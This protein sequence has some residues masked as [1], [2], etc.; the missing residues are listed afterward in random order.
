MNRPAYIDLDD[1]E[2]EAF[3]SER[4]NFSPD[5][6]A[7]F[8]ELLSVWEPRID[9]DRFLKRVR[10]TGGP[11]QVAS[12]MNKLWQA[13]VGLLRTQMVEGE[14]RRVALL[15][16][17]ENSFDFY[18]EAIQEIYVEL[19]ESIGN[20]LPFRSRLEERDLSIPDSLVQVLDNDALVRL[21][22]ETEKDDRSI[23]ALLSLNNYQVI[24]PSTHIRAFTNITMLKIRYFMGNTS[25]LESIARYQDTSLM[26]VKQ[27]LGDKEPQFWL[28]L[29][30]TVVDK[31]KELQAS[32]NVSV[33]KDF[34][35]AAYLLRRLVTAQMEE[36]KE[37]KKQKK[38]REIDLET[39]A[40]SVKE[41]DTPLL[42]Q[43]EMNEII[44]RFREKYASELESF[45]EE[46]Y[47]RYV[48]AKEKRSLPKVLMIDSYYIHRDNFY[49]V[50]LERFQIL[51]SELRHYYKEQMVGELQRGSAGG[52]S[53]FY[54][55]EN[56]ENDIRD[57]ISG[58]DS[59]VASVL[60][61]PALLAEAV[62]LSAKQKKQV[63]SM[64]DL[65]EQ[66]SLYFNPE[67][68]KLL[69]LPTI[70]NLSLGEIYDEAFE[71]L[72]ILRRIWIRLTG[73]YNAVRDKYVSRSVLRS[74]ARKNRP[75]GQ[76]SFSLRDEEPQ[77]AEPRR[78]RP[79][80]EPQSRRER[81]R[82]QT[83]KPQRGS[84]TK[85]A[86]TEK[87]KKPYSKKQQDSAWDAFGNTI[88]KKDE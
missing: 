46:F 34:Y 18:F 49:P 11:S 64:D 80:E 1:R 35:H 22:K 72:H 86:E 8:R 30:S 37:R 20:P 40:M 81:R 76:N 13:R 78:A 16:V 32:R 53:K 61:K 6:R 12:L 55:H 62:I 51:A 85:Q 7:I 27:G 58:R 31:R 57:Q 54:S 71:E 88:K 87:V 67:S 2:R 69:D 14:R 25:L 29:A 17:E 9:Y 4:G 26:S 45:R 39:A 74:T 82:P 43:T 70:F 65:K 5:E 84:R 23:A 52:S 38:E 33:G 44:E 59:F 77:V 41:T 36:A 15:L 47:E 48:H 73:K 83:Y 19:T 3:L 10:E 50:F 79:S 56:F 63:K 24:L 75:S 68:M 21:F 66:L 42:D 60:S 28:T